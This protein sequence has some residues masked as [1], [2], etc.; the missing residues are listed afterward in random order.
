MEWWQIIITAAGILAVS[1][2]GFVEV[3]IR[4]LPERRK[5]KKETEEAKVAARTALEDGIK[6]AKSYKFDRWMFKNLIENRAAPKKLRK[7]LI[8]L[9]SLAAECA[10]WRYEAWQTINT[11]AKLA[12]RDFKGL[13]ESFLQVFGSVLEYVFEGTERTFSE[14]IYI[15]IYRG[16]L[17]FGQVKDS[18][19]EDMWDSTV[20]LKDKKSGEEKLVKFRDVLEDKEFHEFVSRLQKLQD[21]E[22]IKM[23]RDFQARFLNKAESVM[24]E[25]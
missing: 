21:R 16:G 13:S 25:L 4:Y 23:L 17:T 14:H 10:K 7:Q 3:Y 2:T 19:L 1:M 24:K 5:R 20:A 8:E 12:A 6:A 18:V 11:E 9:S 22:S 15:T